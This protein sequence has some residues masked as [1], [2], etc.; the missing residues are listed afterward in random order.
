MKLYM[1]LLWI[2]RKSLKKNQ[3]C[4]MGYGGY[5]FI[6][7]ITL[8]SLGLSP[9]VTPTL[10]KLVRNKFSSFI[11][12]VRY[13]FYVEFFKIE[14]FSLSNWRCVSEIFN[15]YW[16]NSF[17]CSSDYF[18]FI[19]FHKGS[20]SSYRWKKWVTNTFDVLI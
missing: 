5:T 12:D 18:L 13:E 14:W 10:V 7:E 2:K 11:R 8:K 17:Q 9:P 1:L 15:T 16:E 4:F 19:L 6:L 3:K 20:S